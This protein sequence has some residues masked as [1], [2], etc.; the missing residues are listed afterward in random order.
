MEPP[1]T[2]CLISEESFTSACLRRGSCKKQNNA[3]MF[4][5]FFVNPIIRDWRTLVK[6]KN[7]EN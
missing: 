3:E 7:A 2:L 4:D 1:Y 6:K 5:L